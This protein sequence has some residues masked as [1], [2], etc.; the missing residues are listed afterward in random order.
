MFTRTHFLGYW[1]QGAPLLA[2]IL[3]ITSGTML[4]R[5]MSTRKGITKILKAL[6]IYDVLN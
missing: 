5:V 4:G 3:S 2:L 6:K 1:M